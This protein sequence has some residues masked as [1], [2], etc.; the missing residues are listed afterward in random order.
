MNKPKAG[1]LWDIGVRR[2]DSG[3]AYFLYWDVKAEKLYTERVLKNDIGKIYFLI[4]ENDDIASLIKS[5]KVL[6]KNKIIFVGENCLLR[7]TNINY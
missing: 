7:K 5:Y 6:Y 2:F 1:E 4:L 3:D